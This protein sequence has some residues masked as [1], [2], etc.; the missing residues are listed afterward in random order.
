MTRITQILLLFLISISSFA[1]T[2][3]SGFIDRYPIA[4]VTD[5]YSDGDAR[6]VYAY[7]N[8]D[9]PI[10]ISGELNQTTLTLFEKDKKGT[11]KAK[12][13]FE[14]FS[15][16]NSGLEGSW[17]DLSS[18]KQLKI[19]LT[20]KFDID[21]GE[22]IEWTSREI[23]QPVSLRD[24][25]FKLV[26]S[27]EKGSSYAAVSGIKILEK[28]TD[29]LIQKIEMECEL[30]GLMNASVGDYNFD[31][32]GDFSVFESSYAGPNTSS[33]YFLYDPKSKKYFKSEFSGISLE[34]DSESKSIFE[35]NQCCAGTM[36]TTAV[37]KVVKNKMVLV[38][39]HCF[40]WDEEKQ[41]LVE[42]DMKE[43]Q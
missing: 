5:I 29:K 36:A 3:Y 41:D 16:K 25:Y 7:D 22:D 40:K 28:K 11:S 19:K 32:I 31:G 17:T 1:Q 33:L 38:E 27:K 13:V 9:E 43:C 39:E 15:P 21:Y 23:L 14:N 24:S 20:K 6:G 8:Y 4:L 37:Y 34:F 30:R 2:S 35:R 12:L 42:R 10:E 18:G 26:I